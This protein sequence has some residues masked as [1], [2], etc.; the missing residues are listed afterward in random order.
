MWDCFYGVAATVHR[1]YLYSA[2]SSGNITP[3][4]FPLHKW[5]FFEKVASQPFNIY[6]RRQIALSGT[7]D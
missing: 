1:R 6:L 7:R 2:F 3:A 5:M 4:Y